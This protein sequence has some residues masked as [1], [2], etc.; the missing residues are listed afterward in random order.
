MQVLFSE[1]SLGHIK[2]ARA[3]II[4]T[5]WH[6]SIVSM[7]EPNFNTLCRYV[8]S[9]T[10]LSAGACVCIIDAH[11][12][13]IH[14]NLRIRL[15]NIYKSISTYTYTHTHTQSLI[16]LFIIVTTKFSGFLTNKIQVVIIPCIHIYV[17]C[18]VIK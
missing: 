5:W 8:D 18:I 17:P 14:I 1:L 7:F 4:A 6:F 2:W 15:N 3:V 13:P 9:N 16:F 10:V 12:I 11:W